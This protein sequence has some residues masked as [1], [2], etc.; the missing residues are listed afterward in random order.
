MLARC[1]GYGYLRGV[2][3]HDFPTC[4]CLVQ[5]DGSSIDNSGPVI[6]MKR[7]NRNIAKLLNHHV[8]WLEVHIRGRNS[9]APDL[10]EDHLEGFFKFSPPI[11]AHW[12]RSRIEHGRVVI[13]RQTEPLPI[14]IIE[15][16]DELGESILNFRFCCFTLPMREY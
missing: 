14:K 11:C 15:C 7:R 10:L 16:T 12:K 5:H 8:F 4:L 9:V 1:F 3:V 6:E 13:K 2:Q